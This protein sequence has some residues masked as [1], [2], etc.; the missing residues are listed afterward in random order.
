MKVGAAGLIH[1]IMELIACGL[2]CGQ[3][4][5]WMVVSWM[6]ESRLTEFLGGQLQLAIRTN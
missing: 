5:C 4:P 1:A 6:I 3:A 2:T